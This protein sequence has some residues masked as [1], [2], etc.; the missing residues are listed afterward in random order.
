MRRFIY[1][2]VLFVLLVVNPLTT[3]SQDVSVEEIVQLHAQRDSLFDL[4]TDM[5]RDIQNLTSKEYE[6]IVR[7]YLN[8]RENK[9]NKVDSLMSVIGGYG[10][11]VSPDSSLNLLVNSISSLGYFAT[12]LMRTKELII[13][14]PDKR[15]S[16]LSLAA[17]LVKEMGGM[18]GSE[19]SNLPDIIKYHPIFIESQIIVLTYGLNNIQRPIS[20][21]VVVGLEL[22][23]EKYNYLS[24]NRFVGWNFRS[25]IMRSLKER[26]PYD[27]NMLPEIK[28]FAEKIH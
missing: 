26:V 14:Y 24:D 19:M 10:H 7:P 27:K 8:E 15:D 25:G 2:P 6:S 17:S 9:G 20:V 1:V 23:L 12:E 13:H 11:K 5:H 21:Y 22:I 4:V 3:L 18:P 16:L 28:R